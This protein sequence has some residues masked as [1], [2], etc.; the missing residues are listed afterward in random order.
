MARKSS[1]LSVEQVRFKGKK[2]DTVSAGA[3]FH[4]TVIMLC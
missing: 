1:V 2:R 4:A 3:T